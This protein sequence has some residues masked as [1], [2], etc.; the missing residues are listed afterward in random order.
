MQIRLIKYSGIAPT[1]LDLTPYVI[2]CD[3]LYE[4]LESHPNCNFKFSEFSVTADASTDALS[5]FESFKASEQYLEAY[6]EETGISHYLGKLKSAAPVQNW[7]DR[8]VVFDSEHIV[9]QL[10]TKVPYIRSLPA[11]S[12]RDSQINYRL[13]KNLPV[14]IFPNQKIS[15]EIDS[16]ANGSTVRSYT[17]YYLQEEYWNEYKNH[18]DIIGDFMRTF[19]AVP[20]WRNNILCV[21]GRKSII[22]AQPQQVNDIDVLEIKT[23]SGWDKYSSQIVLT[24]IDAATG[25]QYE[26]TGTI[27][28]YLTSRGTIIKESGPRHIMGRGAKLLQTIECNMISN[29]YVGQRRTDAEGIVGVNDL[30]NSSVNIYCAWYERSSATAMNL[31]IAGLSNYPGQVIS[32]PSLPGKWLVEETWKDFTLE[33]TECNIVSWG[34]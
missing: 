17:D 16:V 5:R 24:S 7:S 11:S 34:D 21:R 31:V 13:A 2:S 8:T 12:R 9:A 22:S 10:S 1:I 30:Q 20:I 28:R 19:A 6:D 27:E 3:R 26:Y 25:Q 18:M 32:I 23:T 29:C 33:A 15:Y 4:T 14:S